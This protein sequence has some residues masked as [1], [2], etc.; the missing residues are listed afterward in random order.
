MSPYIFVE[1]IRFT[2][3]T[4][5]LVH[6]GIKGGAGASPHV[7]QTEA[8][9]EVGGVRSTSKGAC[10]RGRGPSVCAH[11]RGVCLSAMFA[12]ISISLFS[13]LHLFS[14]SCV[15][16]CHCASIKLRSCAPACWFDLD[17][18][19]ASLFFLAQLDGRLWA[20]VLLAD[21]GDAYFH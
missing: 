7:V 16:R 5:G 15:P 8:W 4:G 12:E 2:T 9:V 18:S 13:S 3:A 10:V 1:P 20:L 19:L 21:C 6:F 11:A 14:R 17:C